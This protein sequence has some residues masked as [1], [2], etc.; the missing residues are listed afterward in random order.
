MMWD[1][2]PDAGRDASMTRPCGHFVE[3]SRPGGRR[4]VAFNLVSGSGR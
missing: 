1:E 2:R 3:M 4:A